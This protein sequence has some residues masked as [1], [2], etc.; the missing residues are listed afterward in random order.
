MQIKQ[1]VEERLATLEQAISEL[2]RYIR[3][4][5]KEDMTKLELAIREHDECHEKEIIKLRD[6][7]RDSNNKYNQTFRWLIGVFTTAF[8]ALVTLVAIVCK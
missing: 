8:A 7:I 1:S 2:A 4:D 3:S 6:Y 5:T